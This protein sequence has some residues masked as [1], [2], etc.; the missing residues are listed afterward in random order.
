MIQKFSDRY[1]NFTINQLEKNGGLG[2]ALRIAVEKCRNDLIFRMDSDDISAP[3]R[4]KKQ[5]DAYLQEP[6]D[7][8]GGWT[9]GF[10]GNLAS[11]YTHQIM[12]L[13]KI[14]ASGLPGIRV[15]A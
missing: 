12:G 6:A 11:W 7:V 14:S 3:G 1:G 10:V 8:L 15:L 2:N 5:I 4:F 9:L 13:P